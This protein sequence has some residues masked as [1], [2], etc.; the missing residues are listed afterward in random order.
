MKSYYPKA[1]ILPQ[2]KYA[3]HNFKILGTQL[4][5]LPNSQ[6]CHIQKSEFP[7]YSVQFS[8]IHFSY[9]QHKMLKFPTSN[10]QMSR[11][12][13]ST[14]L[15][16]M[17]MFHTILICPIPYSNVTHNTHMPP[18]NT[19]LTHIQISNVP[20]TMPKCPTYKAE[21]SHIQWSSVPY[22]M[23]NVLYTMLKYPMIHIQ[24]PW[25]Y[26]TYNAQMNP[27]NTWMIQIQCSNVPHTMHECP[28]TMPVCDI[29]LHIQYTTLR[30]LI[31]WYNL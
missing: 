5:H 16:K 19:Q 27:H 24:F 1:N 26:G 4:S 10:T 3:S 31:T 15:Y 21:M 28:H 18:R 22:T 17:K 20:H 30:I 9:F 12:K 2:T 14:F 13:H 25:N 23:L 29:G 7:T 11:M 8:H 6:L